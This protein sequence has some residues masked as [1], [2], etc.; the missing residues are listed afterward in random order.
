MACGS[1]CHRLANDELCA[2]KALLALH[3][4]NAGATTVT[5]NA[6]ECARNFLLKVVNEIGPGVSPFLH[7]VALLTAADKGA[8]FWE[9]K[10][11]H[12]L[13]GFL[14]SHRLWELVS[15]SHAVPI[16]IL[17]VLVHDIA[18]HFPGIV[19][20]KV[21]EQASYWTP[22]ECSTFLNAVCVSKR[23]S[24]VEVIDLTLDG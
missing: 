24:E 11:K 4:T 22:A 8:E 1:L 6:D 15:E 9:K 17:R 7:M 2:A 16:D 21:A 13:P 18:V 14:P 5:H 23:R 19:T 12:A 10:E 3:T 20:A